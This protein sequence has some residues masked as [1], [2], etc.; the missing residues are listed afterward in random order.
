MIFEQAEIA[1][2]NQTVPYFDQ[3][4]DGVAEHVFPE[5]VGQIQKRY[6]QR[7]ICFGKNLTVKEWVV[8][9]QELNRYLKD[10]PAHNG[11][12]TQ[13]LNADKF[14]DILEFG[15]LASWH[16]EFTVQGFDPVD[17]GLH[18]FVEFCTHLESCEL[19]EDGPK[20]EKTKKTKIR[21]RKRKAKV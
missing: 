9:V 7:N 6:I 11:N 20:V 13:P 2:G 5:K 21:G 18:K 14:L 17:Q 3:C 4:L 10:F 8:C 12:L 1:R 19:S 15:V 16:R